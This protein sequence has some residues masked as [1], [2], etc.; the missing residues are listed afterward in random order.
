MKCMIVKPHTMNQR[1]AHHRSMSGN[2]MG[3]VLLHGSPGVAG[4]YTSAAPSPGD[5]GM[6]P[7]P[8]G[9]SI[10]KAIGMKLEKLRVESKKKPENIRFS[11]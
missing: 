1:V 7:Q 5:L 9:G 2:G 3:S 4:T 10:G 8:S 6:L 11:V